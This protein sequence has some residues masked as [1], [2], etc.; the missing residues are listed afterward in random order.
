MLEV[1]IDN[2]NHTDVVG[3]STKA[4]PKAAHTAHDQ[5]D[6]HAGLGGIIEFFD[7]GGIDE[8][9]YFG[10]Y[11]S[12]MAGTR[13]GGFPPNQSDEVFTQAARCQRQMV[14][15]LW[16]SIARQQIKEFG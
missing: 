10:N 14:K 11:A 12:E 3:H 2:R 13:L 6:L 7:D 9:V 5:I 4:G 15:L 1:S 8:T 16:P